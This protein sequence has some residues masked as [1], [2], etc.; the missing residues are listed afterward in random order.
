MRWSGLG[1]TIRRPAAAATRRSCTL[2]LAWLLTLWLGLVV[3]PTAAQPADPGPTGAPPAA[4]PVWR[5]GML[6]AYPPFQ[7]WPEG[8][9]PGGA[10]LELLLA[11]ARSA[12]GRIEP[13]R[14]DDFAALL[15]DLRAGRIDVASAMAR[16]PGRETELAF[17]APYATVSQVMVL[18][19]RDGDV[20]LA[21]DLAGRRVAVVAGY[22]SEAQVA[23]LFPLAPRVPVADV[24]QGLRALLEGRAD[25][26]IETL[27]AVTETMDR[28]QLGD[29]RLA[30]RIVLGSGEL[31]LASA[32]ARSAQ[33]APLAGALQALPEGARQAA[34]ARWSASRPGLPPQA[35]ELD[36]A[37]Q[38]V[39]RALPPLTVAV[40]GGQPPFVVAG[41][42]GRPQGLSVD[43]LGAALQRLALPAPQ[44]RVL[45]ADEALAALAR[46]EAQ[47][48]LG[49]PEAAS[50]GSGIGFAGPFISHPLVLVASRQAGLWSLD[51]MA[52]RRL[53]M[54]SQQVPQT[55]LLAQHPRIQA[56]A[57]ADVAACLDAVLDG[58]ADATVA[59]VVSTAMLLA[60][61]G[62]WST[63][64]IVGTAGDLRHDRG[65]AV[66]PA[67]RPL[68]PLLQ[69]ALD[70]L[71]DDEM[72]ALK[73]RWL[74]RPPPRAVAL[75]VLAKAAPWALVFVLA[76][77]GLWWAHSR[78]LRAEVVRRQAAQRLAEQSAAA[79]R[80]FNAFL[81]HEVRNSL[82]SVI[83]GTELLRS[84]R[85][86]TASA[87]SVAEPLAQS[88]RATLA[89]LNGLLDRERLA[90]GALT[91]DPGP[92]RLGTVVPAVLHEMAPA[93]RLAGAVLRWQPPPDDPL[94]MLDALRVQQVLRNLL[95]NAIKYASPGMVEVS[96]RLGRPDGPD[97]SWRVSICVRDQGPG[98]APAQRAAL[99]QPYAGAAPGDKMSRPDSSGLGL[100]LSRDL[101]RAMAGDLTLETPPAG[102]VNACFDFVAPGVGAAPSPTAPHGGRVLMVEDAEVYAMLLRRALEQAGW[103]VTAAGSVADAQRR[104]AASS[105]E[106]LLT[107]QH[108][109]D[110][111]AADVL[112]A[113]AGRAGRRIVMTADLDSQ[114]R[115]LP[116]ADQVL[117]KTADVQQ[118]VARLMVP[119]GPA[120]S[121]D[122]GAAPVALAASAAAPQAAGGAEST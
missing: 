17:S 95:S 88:A 32:A 4:A 102:G 103:Q 22:A 91:L 80:R 39:L 113:A 122:E 58:R 94:L 97:A 107:D 66:S 101:A 52:G 93:A 48:G 96:V 92:A 72:P 118:L 62:R 38:A 31:H 63:L 56:V 109:P 98:L 49:L 33:L 84:E 46:G 90:A 108:L 5:Y 105:F 29:L 23:Q 59:D 120:G 16:T 37:E 65:V 104:L 14:Y 86:G 47:L 57:C 54:P 11:A 26:F 119:A 73:Q 116:G 78:G 45:P 6:A 69:R 106:L 28:L 50:R 15:A 30:R 53:A 64:Q 89:L 114:T 8:G 112:A 110:G 76:A 74:E 34:I 12:G 68:V 7:I 55:L 67:V 36:A 70:A 79:A 19:R 85:G 117:A 27:P 82:H 40:V 71:A 43:V 115:A 60:G 75:A 21:A 18:R 83:A 9:W 42:D 87:A 2:L 61:G 111:S 44:W 13:V 121:K 10:D 35:V 1:R 41:A 24:E 25:L 77:G 3:P 81:A 20:P 99:F 51:Q 100:A